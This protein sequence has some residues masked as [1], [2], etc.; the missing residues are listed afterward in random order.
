MHRAAG[1]QPP[2]S[3]LRY[4]IIIHQRARS[5]RES[6]RRRRREKKFPARGSSLVHVNGDV[7]S[8][9]P[10]NSSKGRKIDSRHFKWKVKLSQPVF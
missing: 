8:D 2:S 9:E 1:M 6:E 10:E 5:E 4:D 3:P 7:R